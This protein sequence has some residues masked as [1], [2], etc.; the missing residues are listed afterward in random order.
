MWCAPALQA[1][2]R[3]LTAR[4]SVEGYVTGNFSAGQATE[5]AGV[6]DDLLTVGRLLRM[7]RVHTRNTLGPPGHACGQPG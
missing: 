5:L 1:F 7:H 2:I 6:V 3:R 4:C